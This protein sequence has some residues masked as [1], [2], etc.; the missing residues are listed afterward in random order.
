MDLN[1]KLLSDEDYLNEL[2]DNIIYN[3]SNIVEKDGILLDNTNSQ[4]I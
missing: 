2:N 3:S 4:Y 1:D